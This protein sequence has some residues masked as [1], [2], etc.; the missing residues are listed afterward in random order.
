VLVVVGK[1][2]K[3]FSCEENLINRGSCMPSPCV[4][5]LLAP[6]PS[7]PKTITCLSWSDTIICFATVGTLVLVPALVESSTALVLNPFVLSQ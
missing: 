5:E 4:A 6:S 1:K 2:S 7:Q 3:G